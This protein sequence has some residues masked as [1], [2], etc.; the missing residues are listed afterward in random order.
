MDPVS[1]GMNG[2]GEGMFVCFGTL[3]P[4]GCGGSIESRGSFRVMESFFKILTIAS[5]YFY[6]KGRVVYGKKREH[7]LKKKSRCVGEFSRA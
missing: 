5:A 6:L 2:L 3:D 1:F 7:Q 4:G